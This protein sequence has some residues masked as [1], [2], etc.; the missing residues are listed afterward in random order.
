MPKAIGEK[1]A[2]ERLPDPVKSEGGI[3]ID[4]DKSGHGQRALAKGVVRSV[5]RDCK[6][7]VKVGDKVLY[8]EFMSFKVDGLDYTWEKDVLSVYED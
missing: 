3:W 5:G 6:Y 8:R 2:I 7:G 1:L 4:A